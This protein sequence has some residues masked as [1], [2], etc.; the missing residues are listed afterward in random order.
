[1]GLSNSPSA[2][3]HCHQVTEAGID[4][5]SPAYY[6]DPHSDAFLRFRDQHCTVI[7]ARG[8]R[9]LPAPVLGH[10]VGVFPTGLL[11]AEGHPAGAG[12]LCPVGELAARGLELQEALL[13]LGAPLD[14]RGMPF[15]AISSEST[16]FAGIRRLDATAN[17]DLVKPVVVNA[18]LG[19]IAGVVRDSP[20]QLRA[21]WNGR[22][23]GTVYM[24][25]YAGKRVLGRW[26]DKT[27]EMLARGVPPSSEAMLRGEDQRRYAKSDRPGL[28]DVTPQ[29][30]KHRYQRRF[31]GL[32][33][34]TRAVKVTGLVG[35][36][37]TL[38]AMVA[39]GELTASAARSMGGELLFEASGLSVGPR[40]TQSYHRLRRQRLGMV[41]ANG[42][43]EEVE[44]DLSTVLEACLDAPAW[45]QG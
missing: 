26:Y 38:A 40:R 37:E 10:R 13:E 12:K 17:V 45:G 14:V 33:K 23:G 2:A 34:A 31:Y 7:S 39:A 44:F 22:S 9:L 43:L 4:T 42:N 8:S 32:Y 16:G 15:G 29:A 24:L 6:L 25:G 21:Q 1:M 5:W 3:T 19:A 41:L 36:A 18:A 20:G 30:V 28:D 11:F 27:A 35:H